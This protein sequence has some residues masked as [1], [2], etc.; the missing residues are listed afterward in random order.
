MTNQEIF[1][2]KGY[3]VVK[4]AIS[5]E[6]RDFVTQYALFDEMQDFTPEGFGTQV[7]NAHSKY[8]DPT[9]ESM[10]LHLHKTMEENT[11]LSLHPT[12]SYYRVYRNGDVLKIHKDRPS[13]EISC[14]LC[15]NYSY[16]DT[17]YQWPIYMAEN[18][19][20]LSPGDMV[21]YRGCDL[22]HWREKF[23]YNKDVWHVQGFFHYV[24]AN[25]P[26]SNFKY[27][28][29]ENVGHLKESRKVNQV[30]PQKPYITFL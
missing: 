19:I 6:L 12:Y 29:R 28:Q 10:L 16:D 20:N 7:E 1:K 14:T 18:K 8:A 2:E 4:N 21:I 9:M 13:C 30:H 15:F 17:K 27:D 22:D 11:G 25:G 26:F 24:D 3:C 5:D 23:D